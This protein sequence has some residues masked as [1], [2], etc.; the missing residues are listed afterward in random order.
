MMVQVFFKVSPED[1][2]ESTLLLRPNVMCWWEIA[3]SSL[4]VRLHDPTN[5]NWSGVG[6]GHINTLQALPSP[7]YLSFPNSRVSK[8][9]E[10]HH[11]TEKSPKSIYCLW[12]WPKVNS[13]LVSQ[14]IEIVKN[15]RQGKLYFFYKIWIDFYLRL[16]RRKNKLAW[17]VVGEL[18][19]SVELTATATACSL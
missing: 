19:V 6:R 18:N 12:E 15:M 3:W 5:D 13:H 4:V 9:K 8:A 10:A 11:G 1:V 16:R 14:L 2:Q 7:L 17:V